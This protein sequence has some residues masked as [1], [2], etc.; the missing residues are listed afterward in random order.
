MPGFARGIKKSIKKSIFEEKNFEIGIA[1]VTPR[2]PVSFLNK[3]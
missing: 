2:V 3:V 1:F